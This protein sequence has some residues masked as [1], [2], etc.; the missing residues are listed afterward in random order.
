MTKAKG[1]KKSTRA[2]QTRAALRRERRI[3]AVGMGLVTLVSFAL[4]AMHIHHGLTT[5]GYV[6]IPLQL[7]LLMVLFWAGTVWAIIAWLR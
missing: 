1:K 5:D 4:L 2:K 3:L 7:L 6:H